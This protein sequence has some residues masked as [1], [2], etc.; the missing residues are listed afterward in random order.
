[1]KNKIKFNSSLVSSSKTHTNI[2]ALLD[3]ISSLNK[4]RKKPFITMD[5]NFPIRI[6]DNVEDKYI[7]QLPKLDTWCEKWLEANP[8]TKIIKGEYYPYRDYT[9]I[10]DLICKHG[11]AFADQALKECTI[12]G[13]GMSVHIC[14]SLAFCI[15]RKKIDPKSLIDI[16]TYGSFWD[17]IS[18]H[19]HA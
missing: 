12:K 6:K 1:M 5:P 10:H 14:D 2:D 19:G 9:V 11:K 3:G 18:D 13:R 7:E 17:K 4:K 16:P 8:K 15:Y